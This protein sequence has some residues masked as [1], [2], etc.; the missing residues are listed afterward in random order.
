MAIAVMP[1]SAL[2]TVTV[3]ASRNEMQSHSTL[4]S[5]VLHQDRALADGEGGLGA[6]ADEAG[7]VLTVGVDVGD[8][9]ASPA[10]SS[11]VRQS[12]RIVAPPRRSCIARAARRLADIACRR[13]C[14]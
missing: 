2:I 7:L 12:P 6:D 10:W 3:A 4:P 14:R 1:P 11:S 5:G 8:R 13:R 9:R